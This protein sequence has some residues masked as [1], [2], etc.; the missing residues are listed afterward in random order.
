MVLV[1]HGET[2]W[3]RSGR[4]TGTT[5]IPL[6]DAGREQ[7]V[8][9]GR[10][11]A[12]R[13]FAL[14]LTSPLGRAEETCGLARLGGRAETTDA[15]AEWDYGA[16]EGRTTA[17]IRSEDPGWTIWTGDPPGG[18]TLAEVSRRADEVVVRAREAQG[19]TV[20]F[21]HGHLLRVLGARWLGLPPVAGRL[22]ALDAGSVSELGWE[23]AVPVVAHWNQ[24]P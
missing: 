4:H 24:R 15:L 11:L 5:D 19:D 16:Y 7:A 20:C 6:T 3:S 23:H 1:R 10:F 12:G 9:V 2:E 17:D 8:A 22:L 14:V 13:R 18:E 21:A